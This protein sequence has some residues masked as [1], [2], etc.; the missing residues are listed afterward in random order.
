MNVGLF[1]RKGRAS[2]CSGPNLGGGQLGDV[3]VG[4]T[5][6]RDEL[7]LQRTRLPSRKRGAHL[8][9]SGSPS[10]PALVA[11]SACPH[12]CLFFDDSPP[13]RYFLLKTAWATQTRSGQSA[14]ERLRAAATT[15]CT[16]TGSRGTQ[17]PRLYLQPRTTPRA[18]WSRASRAR[19]ALQSPSR[20]CLLP[21]RKHFLRRVSASRV[22]THPTVP[23]GA[24]TCHA[25]IQ[26][27]LRPTMDRIILRCSIPP[28]DTS[29][30]PTS[31]AQTR[32]AGLRSLSG[33]TSSGG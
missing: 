25:Y 11:P 21:W 16:R 31:Y 24:S 19:A 28:H 20:S 18:A 32:H 6:A 22:A 2:G 33:G 29:A 3:N 17:R 9:Q 12:P 27:L 5:L 13:V 7:W 30:G 4:C 26:L 1:S 10:R 23:L 15:T 8:E 14:L